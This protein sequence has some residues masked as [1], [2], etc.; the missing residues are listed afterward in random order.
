MNEVLSYTEAQRAA[1]AVY[2][3]GEALTFPIVS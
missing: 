3:R 2:N 1:D